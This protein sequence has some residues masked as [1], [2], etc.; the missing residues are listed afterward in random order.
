MPLFW[1]SFSK[2]G[3]VKGNTVT[4]AFEGGNIEAVNEYVMR[5]VEATHHLFEKL[6]QYI[7]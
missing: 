7:N 1:D 6:R 2:G 3:G 5:D 4:K